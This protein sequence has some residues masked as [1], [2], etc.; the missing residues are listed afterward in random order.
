ML[1]M[2]GA[3][4]LPLGKQPPCQTGALPQGCPHLA[5]THGDQDL[6]G[7]WPLSSCLPPGPSSA[8]IA[9]PIRPHP[10]QAASHPSVC[11][12]QLP[13]CEQEQGTPDPTRLVPV[14]SHR[15]QRSHPG[16][17]QQPHSSSQAIKCGGSR[18][19]LQFKSVK[20]PRLT[21]CPSPGLPPGPALRLWD[22]HSPK[23]PRAASAP[24]IA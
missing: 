10:H 14:G 13:A 22:T 20:D 15:G 1:G 18:R 11:V 7:G 21:L 23:P 12:P 16:Q 17:E 4:S 2:G 3:A 5:A 24:A 9:S 19:R 8:L 6:F